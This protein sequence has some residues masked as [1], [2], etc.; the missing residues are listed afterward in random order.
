VFFYQ[1]FFFFFFNLTCLV[2]KTSGLFFIPILL[3]GIAEKFMGFIILFD[4][5]ARGTIR[6]MQIKIDLRPQVEL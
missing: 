2:V 3:F 5:H 6:F 1:K 4:K